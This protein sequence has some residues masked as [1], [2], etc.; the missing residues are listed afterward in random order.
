MIPEVQDCKSLLDLETVLFEFARD[1]DKRTVDSAGLDQLVDAYRKDLQQ[2]SSM[3]EI[4][5][6]FFQS[7]GIDEVITSTL[8]A[9]TA[10]QGFGFNRAF[11]LEVR[12]N[13]LH[14]RLGIGPSDT[15]EAHRIWDRISGTTPSLR[16][17][18]EQLS[19]AGGPPDRVT[20][21]I[22]L[23]IELPF[24]PSQEDTSGATVGIIKSCLEGKPALITLEDRGA[25]SELELRLFGVLGSDAVAVVPLKVQDR[26]AGVILA[27]NHI[28]CKPITHAD[29]DLLRTFSGYAAIAVER[30]H[31]HGELKGKIEELRDANRELQENQRRLLRSE[32]LSALGEMSAYVSHEIRNPLVA[33]G[34]LARSLLGEKGMSSDSQELLEIIASEVERLER[35]LDETLSNVRGEPQQTSPTSVDLVRE[36]ND[37][38][39]VFREGLHRPG[40][41]IMLGAPD[42]PIMVP[43]FIDPVRGALSNLLKNALDSFDSGGVISVQIVVKKGWVEIDVGDTGA[44]VAEEIRDLIFEPFFTTKNDGTGVGLAITRSN[45]RRI[46]GDISLEKSDKFS[47]LFRIRLPARQTTENEASHAREQE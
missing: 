42:V 18:L 30:S 23:T 44:G 45:I 3:R 39:R 15:E 25:L 29:I 6:L 35:F 4:I 33:V 43:V 8:V 37:V 27:D 2:L 9:V 47:T 10:G 12:D 14:G 1:G 32:K 38:V 28:T 22:A 16:E 20:Q 11:F 17:M 41:E 21:E 31:L 24:D 36:V 46:G 34:G 26:L 13:T 19:N 7:M 5:D 40:V